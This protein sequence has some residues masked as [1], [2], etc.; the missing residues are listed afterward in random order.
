MH[1]VVVGA[2]IDGLS[3]AWALVKRGIR[4]T[5]LEQA[6]V[7]PN[8]LSA[9][10]DQHRIIRRAYGGLGGYQRR[11]GE[12]YDSWAELW[13]DIGENHLV[14]TGF[15]LVSQTAGDEA[16]VYHAAL[17]AGGYP[18]EELSAEEAGER[19]PFFDPATIRNVAHSPE[20]GVLLCRKIAA[21]LLT[22]LKDQG[23]GIMTDARVEAVDAA[24]GAVT[25]SDGKVIRGDHI[26]V[27]AGAWVLKLFPHLA[28]ALTPYRTAVAYLAPPSNLKEAWENAP[29]I[30]DVGGT[31]DGYIIPPV[32]GT[33][34]KFG[35]GTHKRKGD[36]DQDRVPEANEGTAIRDL[37]A[38]PVARIAEYEV[39]EVATCAYTFTSDEHFMLVGEDRLTI[40]SACSG[41]G[42]KF[43]AAVGQRIAKGIVC[44]EMDQARAW[45]EARD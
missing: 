30:L 9:S 23:A 16:D 15:L 36:P 38:P 6:S 8:P 33:G 35:A 32:A 2:G 31:V 45:L 22:W 25:L 20:G 11:I 28:A 37:F 18:A 29:V 3:V 41:H 27:T 19:Y 17:R 34:L 44:N 24:G 26:V 13:R 1:V 39:T 43:G 12:A 40:V 10:G 14:N 7:I 42:Y 5:L 4:V 21:G